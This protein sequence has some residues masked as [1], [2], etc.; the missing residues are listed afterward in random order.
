ML[1]PETLLRRRIL[2]AAD[3]YPSSP[4]RSSKKN[5]RSGFFEM[6]SLID[7]RGKEKG[8][9]SYSP[10]NESDANMVNASLEGGGIGQG[11][12]TMTDDEYQEDDQLTS[13]QQAEVD[14]KDTELAAELQPFIDAGWQHTSTGTWVDP[15]DSE[16][17]LVIDPMFGRIIYS[18]KY[19]EPIKAELD[20]RRKA[21]E[22]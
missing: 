4:R 2:C 18:A 7:R 20:R 17:W 5:R 15:E 16:R 11:V 6:K 21:G 1:Q 14:R 9:L 22:L 3:P 19:W 8:R 10:P 12:Q 13:E